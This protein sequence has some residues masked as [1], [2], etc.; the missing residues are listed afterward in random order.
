LALCLCLTVS[1]LW[2]QKKTDRDYLRSG[3]RLYRDSMYTKAEVDYR[4]AIEA[5]SRFPQAHFN[6]GNALLRQQKPKEAMQ[7]YEQAVKVETNK[8]RLASIYHNMGV[9]LQSQ[10]Q[11]GP[12]IECYKNALRRN[13]ADNES[14]Y[15]LVLCQHQLKNN[16]Q[17]D[18]QNDNKENKDGK[19]KNKK[20]D[21]QKQQQKQSQ[22]NEE[23]MSKENAE[24]LLNAAM[25]DE[26]DT[27][28]RIRKAMAK[29]RQRKLEKQ[30]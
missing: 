28:E 3:N 20:E 17:Q 23:N 9:I 14:R 26:K 27:Q 30:W 24:Q 2:A 15:N 22:Q 5:N 29:P 13:P 18:Q 12:A 25:Q 10:K 11:F 8:G 7:A 4:K 16:P 1:L 19:D 21:Q 6:L